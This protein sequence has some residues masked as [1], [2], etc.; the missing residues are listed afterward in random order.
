[1]EATVLVW[2]QLESNTV[3]WIFR[4]NH[5]GYIESVVEGMVMDIFYELGEVNSMTGLFSGVHQL[6]A[7]WRLEWENIIV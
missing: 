5:N 4:V 7:L 2:D 1:M 3:E 6:M